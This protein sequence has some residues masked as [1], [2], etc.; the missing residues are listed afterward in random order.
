MTKGDRNSL[1]WQKKHKERR[2]AHLRL[3]YYRRR[4][5]INLANSNP[6]AKESDLAD[7]LYA[8]L[9]ERWNPF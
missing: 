4:R 9:V 1:E 7:V 6:T 2:R 5:Q 3:Y 8:S